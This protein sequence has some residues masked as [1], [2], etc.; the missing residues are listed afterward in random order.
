MDAAFRTAALRCCRGA[1]LALLLPLSTLTAFVGNYLKSSVTKS[2]SPVFK[3][4]KNAGNGIF[5]A[6][7]ESTRAAQRGA[8]G[9]AVVPSA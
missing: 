7:G 6:I 4:I 1:W 9:T 8:F 2:W 3:T 5:R